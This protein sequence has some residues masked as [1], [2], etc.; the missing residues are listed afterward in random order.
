LNH[1]GGAFGG[2]YY[3]FIRSFIDGRWYSFNDGIVTGIDP[4]DIE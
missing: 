1:T 3:A 2:H 4:N